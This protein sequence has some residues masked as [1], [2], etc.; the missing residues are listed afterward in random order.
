M[1]TPDLYAGTDAGTAA[2]LC[3]AM[4][5]ADVRYFERVALP[6]ADDVLLAALTAE[7]PWRSEEI[8]VWGKRHL[9]PRL[10]AWYGDP[11]AAYTYSGIDL[12]PLPWTPLLAQLRDAV[13]EATGATYNSVLLNLYRNERDSMG[14]HS[15]DEPTLGPRPVIA[16]LS[17]GATRTFVLKHRS[18]RTLR[19]VRI[20][21]P[22]GS[23]LLMQGDT[24]RCWKHGIDKQT[25]PLGP[26]L[27]LTFRRI[28]G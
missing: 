10:S 2:P 4:P 16:S 14:M 3:V 18:D 26:R 19:P 24:Q 8:V 11:G 13:A 17:L 9:Q 12:H 27:N 25:R 1:S 23:L 28:V 20:A 5:D 15:D 21:L 6:A 22:S 7:T